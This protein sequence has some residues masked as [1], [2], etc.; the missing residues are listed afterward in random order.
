M[1]EIEI[2]QKLYLILKIS[3]FTKGLYCNTNDLIRFAE[4]YEAQEVRLRQDKADYKYGADTRAGGLRGNFSNLVTFLG[5]FKKGNSIRSYYGIGYKNQIMN[6]IHRG[7]VLLNIKNE[8][9][10]AYTKSHALKQAIDREADL[11]LIREQQS[12]IDNY[13]KK[14]REI[15][16]QRDAHFPNESIVATKN[17]VSFLRAKIN[18]YKDEEI[19]EYRLEPYW[20]GKKLRKDNIHLMIVI[21]NTQDGWG[22]QYAV[23]FEM[24]A[25]NT[26][27]FLYFNTATKQLY[28][29]QENEYPVI[30]MEKAKNSF[31]D[32]SANV[33]LRLN[34]D[35]DN[36]KQ[37]F[38]SAG[39]REQE[40][41]EFQKDE[42]SVF[43]DMFLQWN[44]Q[45]Q[46]EDKTVVDIAV[47]SSGGPDV[48]LTF[49]GGTEQKLELE[50]SW[51]NYIDH[52]HHQSN[53]WENCWL[54]AEEEW[55]ESKVI[56]LF[57]PHL[58][59]NISRIPTH[60]LSIDKQD[61]KRKLF[62]VDWNIKNTTKVLLDFDVA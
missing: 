1:Y 43:V 13:L 11:Y 15:G 5:F 34:Y 25:E 61:K 54:W 49:A 48:R 60:F 41:K 36:L 31:S 9:Y 35:W 24:L 56:N 32:R 47:S 62:I 12:H 22:D 28:D 42:Y 30:S 44:K 16:L 29:E 10:Y 27:L 33:E 4:K 55:D 58:R 17:N 53:A 37:E 19:I 7:D 38:W 39:Q 50:H 23:S 57:T 2:P 20:I 46:I 40:N 51:K 52:K 59:D 18:N 45:F 3:P 26:P 8:K 21:P 14:H 6:A